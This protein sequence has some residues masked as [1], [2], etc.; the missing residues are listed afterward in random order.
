MAVSSQIGSDAWHRSFYTLYP[1]N[2]KNLATLVGNI[3]KPSGDKPALLSHSEVET[4]F[5]EFGHLCHGILTKTTTRTFAGTRVPRGF[6]ELPSRLHENW[7]WEHNALGLFAEHYET[8]EKIQNEVFEKMIAARNYNSSIQMMGQLSFGKID[9][10]FHHHFKKF[11]CMNVFQ[12]NELVLKDFNFIDSDTCSALYRVTQLRIL[13]K[14]GQRSW[15]PTFSRD[16]R[17][18][19][20]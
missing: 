7:A 19:E 8:G 14:C 9:L 12:I 4:I 3:Q 2:P 10:E 1:S 11:D 20:Y 13:A 16:L 15:K 6:V 18:K 17:R 5:H